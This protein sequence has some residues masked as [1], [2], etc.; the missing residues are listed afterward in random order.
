MVAD[1]VGL[2]AGTVGRFVKCGGVASGAPYDCIN[3]FL[4]ASSDANCFW[5][6]CF[7]ARIDAVFVAVGECVGVGCACLLVL[8]SSAL[9]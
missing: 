3:I 6:V 4:F 5:T 7:R 9:I 1:G 8:T 2:S